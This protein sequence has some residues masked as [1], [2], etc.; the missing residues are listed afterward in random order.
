M[1]CKAPTVD[2]PVC[3][4]AGKEASQVLIVD[5]RRSMLVPL[6]VF[7]VV[8]EVEDVSTS[9]IVRECLGK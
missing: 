1:E 3:V 2:E 9:Q 6:I 5:L 7:E 4:N 8:N